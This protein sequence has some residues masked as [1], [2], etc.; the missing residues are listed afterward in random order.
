MT[1]SIFV[2]HSFDHPDKLVR[3]Q[4]FMRMRNVKHVDYSI[5][6]W[7]QLNDDNP[8][9]EIERRI[10]ECDRVLVI[11]T[12]GSHKSPW[13]N[14]EVAWGRKYGKPV[15]GI[16]PD[17]EAGSPIPREVLE[18]NAHLIGWR[19]TSL[20]KALMLEDVGSYRALDL[21]ED[22]DF[23]R[24][25]CSVVAA[26][27]AISLLLVGYQ[28]HQAWKLQQ[29]LRS[30]GIEVALIEDR[31]SA[32][33]SAIKSAGIGAMLMAIVGLLFGRTRGQVARLAALGAGVGVGISLYRHLKVRV[34]RFETL[35]IMDFEQPKAL[36]P[37]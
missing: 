3:I 35:T 18:A 11:L 22:V 29:A 25:V 31:W 13:I 34:R 21:A 27:G 19:A 33:R 37:G 10:S 32:A 23:D 9:P 15:I 26:T 7:D 5:P 17:G 30:R 20:E 1:L 8:Q 12:K 14:Q 6:V 28:L 4:E 36:G 2:S 16:W 24:A